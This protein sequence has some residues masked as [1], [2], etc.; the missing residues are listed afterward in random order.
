MISTEN[1]IGQIEKS[2]PAQ[3]CGEREDLVTLLFGSN[4]ECAAWCAKYHD[5]N[6]FADELG[7]SE[8]FELPANAH[9]HTHTHA[10]TH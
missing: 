9:A 7:S 5:F 6:S 4:S 10:H 3:I 1:S 2:S 8:G